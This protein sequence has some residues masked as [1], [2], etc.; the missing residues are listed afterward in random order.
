MV[1]V[2]TDVAWSGNAYR[3]PISYVSARPELDPG[4]VQLPAYFEA[5]R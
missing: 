2:A 5:H 4:D 3:R 1:E